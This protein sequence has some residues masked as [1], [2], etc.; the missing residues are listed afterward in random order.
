[1]G[2]E[3]IPANRCARIP[4]FSAV[5]LIEIGRALLSCSRTF[6]YRAIPK[7]REIPP[8]PSVSQARLSCHPHGLGLWRKPLIGAFA[9]D[10]MAL[11]LQVTS[12]DEDTTSDQ[13]GYHYQIRV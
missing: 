5:D 12:P 1:M 9:F 4:P 8:V 3:P 2:Y 13:Q 10:L 11:V 6:P 7:L